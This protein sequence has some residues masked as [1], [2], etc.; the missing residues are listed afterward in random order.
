MAKKKRKSIWYLNGILNRTDTK[1][2][3]RTGCPLCKGSVSVTGK[4]LL[5]H[6][7][8]RHQLEFKTQKFGKK[9]AGQIAELKKEQERE[10]QHLKEQ[11]LID[12]YGSLE[13]ARLAELKEVQQRQIEMRER[14]RKKIG[15]GVLDP[16]SVRSAPGNVSYATPKRRR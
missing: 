12:R 1:S 4:Q 3:E 9:Y 2:N 10:R 11:K 7:F 16:D 15:A 6:L 13:K 8:Y 14:E 5:R